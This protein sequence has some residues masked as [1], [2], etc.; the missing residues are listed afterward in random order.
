MAII[1]LSGLI[2][3]I[4]GSV[5]GTTFQRSGAGLIMRNK[6]QTVGQGTNSQSI[7]RVYQSQLNEQWLLL[8]DAQRLLWL[9]FSNYVNG[10][11]RSI[12]KSSTS[13]AGKMHFIAINHKLLQY[14]KSIIL[15]PTFDVAEAAYIPCPPFYTQSASLMNYSEYLDTTTQV[16]ITK[17]SLPQSASTLTANTGFRTLVYS[18]VDGYVQDWAAAYEATYGVPLEIGKKYWISLQ[19]INYIKGTIGPEVRQLVK[20]VAGVGIGYMIVGS[21]NQVG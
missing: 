16:L 8:T 1:A 13:N 9:Q 20:Y 6:P 18:Q 11:G 10:N 14:G 5:G 19:A 7:Q 17:V 3:D 12:N 2:T 21:T 4:R 15:E